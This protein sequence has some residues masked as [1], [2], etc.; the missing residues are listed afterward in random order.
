MG[1]RPL[2]VLTDK[3]QSC[4]PFKRLPTTSLLSPLIDLRHGVEVLRK[5]FNTKAF[6]QRSRSS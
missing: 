6:R 3:D 5:H 2:T 1:Y 4:R